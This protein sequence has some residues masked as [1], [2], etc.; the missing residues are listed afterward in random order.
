M[1]APGPAMELTTVHVSP[2]RTALWSI[3]SIALL[4]LAACSSDEG[5]SE[6]AST[7][8]GAPAEQSPAGPGGPSLQV[9]A[10]KTHA[11]Q[12][13]DEITLTISVSDFSLAGDAIGAA[14]KLGEGHYRVYLDETS[15]EA[16]L[17][18]GADPTTKVKIPED[19]TDGSHDL[20]VK[21]YNNDKT[22]L[23]PAAEAS[24]LLIVYRL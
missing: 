17:A 9:S 13:G 16:L 22:P 11:V 18:E 20:L 14:A 1:P 10:D 3:L 7:K 8:A 23:E 15:A 5:T 4:L 21:L 24:V 2:K 6:Q 19:I 12:P